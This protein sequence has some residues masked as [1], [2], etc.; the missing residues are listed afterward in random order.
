M[1]HNH[2]N[3]AMLKQ[4]ATGLGSLVDDVVFLGGCT[5]GLLITDP[6]SPTIRETDDVDMIVEISTHHAYHD[7]TKQLK[8][9]GFK[10]DTS[11]HAP[12]C[13]LLY[14]LLKI[15]VMPTHED[16]L[17]FTNLWY[18]EAMTHAAKIQLSNQLHIQMVTA[19]YF[20]ATKLEAFYNRGQHDYIASHDLEDLVAVIDGRAS[21]I[22][23]IQGSSKS[24]QDYLA[25]EF[26]N[27]I[28]VDDFQDA[29]S[30]HL[31]P[32]AASQARLPLLQER[33]K[34]ISQL[35]SSSC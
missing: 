29:L 6:A 24:L 1:N 13:R 30:G 33:L 23:D 15:D 25:H 4:V 19:P 12:I 2:P 5:T 27:L 3:I 9:K 18:A 32:D 34:Q 7:F 16:I 8:T 22:E 17:G 35:N 31:P 26:N 14:G 20:L 21:I 28:H 11:E 10:E